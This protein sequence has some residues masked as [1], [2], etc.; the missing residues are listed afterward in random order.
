[1]GKWIVGLEEVGLK[2]LAQ[3]GGKNAALGEMIQTLVPLG[4]AVP[5]GFVVTADAYRDFLDAAKL[6]GFIEQQLDR[7]D[8]SDLS[9]LQ[10]VG[11]SIRKAIREAALPEAMAL[12]ILERYHRLQQEHGPD[13][14]VAVRSSAT[15]E[16]L[17]SASFA[18]QHSTVLGVAGDEDLLDAVRVCMASL[19]NDRAIHYRIDTGFGRGAVALS[20]GIQ[21]LVR[22]DKGGS[23]VLFTLDPETGF[24]D[25]IVI[26]AIW[27]LGE[28]IVQG[29][30]TPEE[31]LWLKP[32]LGKAPLPCIGR[33]MANQ[34]VKMTLR[35]VGK[36]ALRPVNEPL[37]QQ[38]Q[39]H[40]VLTEADGLQLALWGQLI[41]QKMGKLNGKPTPMDVE[42]AKDGLTGK[43]YIVQ[44]RPETVQA[45]RD[46]S[47]I[48]S[49]RVEQHGALLLEGISVGQSAAV[50]R[51]RLIPS[52]QAMHE[53][54]D[55]EVLVTTATDPDW[56][57]IMK[58]AA[59]IITERG[60][61]TSHAAIVSRELGVPAIVGTGDAL[62]RILQGQEVTLDATQARGYVYAGAGKI[63]TE[64]HS[65]RD[66]PPTR[67]KIMLNLA[68]PDAAFEKAQLPVAGV[69]LAREEFIIAS[70]VGI[71]PLAALDPSG[72][73]AEVQQKMQ[74]RARGWP[75]LEAFYVDTLAMGIGQIVGAF[76]PRPVIV[77]FSDFK[78]NEYRAL[79]GGDAFE[80]A[81]EN[82]M[83]GWR[84]A[85]RYGHPDFRAAFALE[86]RAMRQVIERMGLTNLI[87]MV[88]FCR[89]PEEGKGVLREMSHAGLGS[90][91]FPAAGVPLLKVYMMCELPSNVVLAEDFLELFDG[92]SIGS[93]DLTQLV[94][95]I[96]RDSPRLSS[97]GNADHPAVRALI[98][99]AIAACKRHRLYVGIC[100]Q[101][102]SDLPGFVS[103]LVEQG[104]ESISLSPDALF[105]TWQTVLEAERATDSAG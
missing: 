59:G 100:G 42:W 39:N 26:N 66:L 95:G 65:L 94:L 101:D 83:L 55:G 105:K 73:P 87:P 19:F 84:G 43:L 104:I 52:A 78:T 5:G 61:R 60:G 32:L 102:P 99:E 17:P 3:V 85:S 14:L 8:S 79:L 67:T 18:G 80:P 1:M 62:Q 88:P 22:S 98:A 70:R 76:Y 64:E 11:E 2:D 6:T 44:A 68:T 77:R 53:F 91:A 56:E 29:E 97:I 63:V 69:G 45:H 54:Q 74:E 96:D 48:R 25:V 47:V 31:S 9:K 23:G 30:V 71:H 13:L 90:R 12:Q 24:R 58:R 38:E 21:Q 15:A 35:A 33:Q 37:S 86:C 27:G 92:F 7:L 4:V 82:P 46:P 16:D 89:T 34:S 28:L 51:A 75:S 10:Q 93:N 36:E 72:V 57:P 20:V 81:E 41:E 49:S 40:F 103:F 50:G